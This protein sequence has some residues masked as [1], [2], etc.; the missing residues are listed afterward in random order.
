[1]NDA[2]LAELKK[3]I[4]K[5]LMEEAE[6]ARQAFPKREWIRHWAGGMEAGAQVAAMTIMKHMKG[7]TFKR[8]V[9][10]S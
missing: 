7:A 1:M 4:T 2:E 6:R 9:G 5:A 3:E 8:P 10:V